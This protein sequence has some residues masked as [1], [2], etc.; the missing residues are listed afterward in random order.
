MAIL[1]KGLPDTLQTAVTLNYLILAIVAMSM[2]FSRLV[3]TPIFLIYF[4][5]V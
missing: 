4:C 5:Y 2:Y 3:A 1:D